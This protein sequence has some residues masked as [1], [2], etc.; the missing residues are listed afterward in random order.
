MA[1][2][3]SSGP[4]RPPTPLREWQ[5]RHCIPWKM[6]APWRS[7]GERFW[8]YFA[9]TVSWL[10]ASIFGLHGVRVP[11]LVKTPQRTATVTRTRT[12]MGRRC[13]LFTLPCVERESDE[14]GEDDDRHDQQDR[15]FEIRRQVRE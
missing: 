8:R 15:S 1:T 5:L 14:D 7:T 9:G 13:P 11:R 4:R 3:S 2:V 10:Q 12:A 6:M